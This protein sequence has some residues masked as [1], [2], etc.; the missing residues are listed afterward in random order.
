M[1]LPDYACL[2]RLG[3]HFAAGYFEQPD[4]S[5]MRRWSLAVRRRFENRALP[6]YGGAWLY[7]SGPVTGRT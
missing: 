1:V 6:A 5:L 2:M 3:E 4:A 7:P